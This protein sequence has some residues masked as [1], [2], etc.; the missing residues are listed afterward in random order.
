ME[1]PCRYCEESGEAVLTQ[2]QLFFSKLKSQLKD[3]KKKAKKIQ[4]LQ[5][6][7]ICEDT[8]K[9]A[10][11]FKFLSLKNCFGFVKEEN[12]LTL[13]ISTTKSKENFEKSKDKKD[14]KLKKIFKL[15]NEGGV[16][17]ILGGVYNGNY[18]EDYFV[19]IYTIDKVI[20]LVKNIEKKIQ[21]A[22]T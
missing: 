15:F 18:I 8:I 9:F 3:V 16:V 11:E 21:E 7:S 4:Q 6:N 14:K 1:N 22:Q 19:F 20:T 17:D 12:Q 5:K 13:K 10:V 2:D